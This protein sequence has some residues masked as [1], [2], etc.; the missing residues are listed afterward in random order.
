MLQVPSSGLSSWPPPLKYS[1]CGSLHCGDRKLRLGEGRLI[2]WSHVAR[3]G[4]VQVGNQIAWPQGSNQNH[5]TSM[6]LL[7]W[8]LKCAPVSLA[9]LCRENEKGSDLLHT[10]GASYI[11][12]FSLP[13]SH[14]SFRPRCCLGSRS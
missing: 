9:G 4:R 12:W 8:L 11:G 6:C 2:D 5:S 3:S 14:L 10:G 7:Y 13:F 1:R